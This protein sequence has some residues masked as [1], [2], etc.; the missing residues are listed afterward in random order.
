MPAPYRR[1]EV[2]IAAAVRRRST[3]GRCVILRREVNRIIGITFVAAIVLLFV[4]ASP[5]GANFVTD[6]YWTQRYNPACQRNV[7]PCMND[8]SVLS[9]N[10]DLGPRLR[11]AVEG[12]LANSYENT[13]IDVQW[14][15][16]I[17]EQLDVLYYV[18]DLPGTTA[19]QYFCLNTAS[20]YQCDH[21]HII[22]DGTLAG[23]M[24]D[25]L[26]RQLACHETG[27]SVGLLHPADG[28]PGIS[29]QNPNYQCMTRPLGAVDAPDLGGHNAGHL[30]DA[31]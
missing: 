9:W 14:T 2:R 10:H 8:D 20:A 19:G 31:Y 6:S 23:G 7:T 21:A 3:A 11:A 1:S 25:R 24:S 15:N 17:N 30:N 18:A 22:F 12:T 27:H 4:P 28:G 26:L 16:V 5:A 29:D 13:D